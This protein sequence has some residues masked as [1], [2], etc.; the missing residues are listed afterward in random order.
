[1]KPDLYGERV[2]LRTIRSDDVDDLFEIYGH[3]Q[4]MQFASDPTFTGLDMMQQM[5]ESVLL[6]EELNESLEWA[7]VEKTSSKV[8]GI[9]GL[10]AFSACRTSC[11]VGCL[12]NV[13]YWKQGYMSEALA[14]LLSYAKSMGINQLIADI[15]IGNFRSK[16]LFEKLGFKP[17]DDLFY[18]EL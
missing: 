15:D 3:E 10:H 4:T 17:K 5:L 13:I 16:A 14:L 18:Y 1:M 8:I 11:E 7:I 9:C 6:L 2:V 12:L